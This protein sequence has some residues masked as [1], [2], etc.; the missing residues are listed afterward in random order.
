MVTETSHRET[1][2]LPFPAPG[3]ADTGVL[4][5]AELH[6]ALADWLRV[7]GIRVLLAQYG[8]CGAAV[9][10][11]CRIAGVRLVVHFHGF[12]A[13]RRSILETYA[14]LYREMF[15]VA[16]AVIAVSKP[17]CA[18][19]AAISC[20]ESKLVYNPY[21]VQDHFFTVRPSFR[22]PVFVFVGRFVEKKGPLLTLEAFRSVHEMQPSAKLWMAGDGP[23]LSACRDTVRIYGLE[24]AVMFPGILR[25]DMVSAFLQRGWAFIQHSMQAESGDSE[26]TPVAILE[27][28]AAGLPVVSTRHAGIPEAVQ[29]EVSGLL[30]DEGDVAGMSAAMCRLLKN[31]GLARR[32]GEAGRLH[33][34]EWYTMKRYL[35]TL[36][37]ALAGNTA[38]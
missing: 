19:L 34:R 12:D 37:A 20:P 15:S 6:E 29:D 35:A 9:A 13:S 17:M 31:P 25:H 14:E 24:N 38:T 30:V 32:M 3:V 5:G 33:M 2:A 8:V 4:P 26:G 11:A 23:L 1:T 28:A 22:D 10:P 36:E 18:K 16:Q 27:A 21:G 7:H